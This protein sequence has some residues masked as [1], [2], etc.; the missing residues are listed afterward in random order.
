ML[1]LII[2]RDYAACPLFHLPETNN[3]VTIIVYLSVERGQRNLL[4]IQFVIHEC[5]L[6]ANEGP[7]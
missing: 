2:S 7:W 6:L 5:I 3:G 1:G 4:V